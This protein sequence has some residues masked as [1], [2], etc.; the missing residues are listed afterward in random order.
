MESLLPIAVWYSMQAVPDIFILLQEREGRH[1]VAGLIII[2][3]NA[4]GVW[5]PL[6]DVITTMLW[7]GGQVTRT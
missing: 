1:W 7:I 6:G 4:D 5:S 2:A 3:G